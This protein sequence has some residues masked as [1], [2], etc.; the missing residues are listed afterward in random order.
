[1][2]LRRACEACKRNQRKDL[3]PQKKRERGGDSSRERRA[4]SV[5][6]ERACWAPSPF[7]VAGQSVPWAGGP[8]GPAPSAGERGHAC[9]LSLVSATLW[10]VRRFRVLLAGQGVRSRAG[11][12]H[13]PGARPLCGHRHGAT[14]PTAHA[15]LTWPQGGVSQ[16]LAAFRGH[17]PLEGVAA[18]LPHC[19]QAGP[20]AEAPRVRT[21][22]AGRPPLAAGSGLG[23]FIDIVGIKMGAASWDSWLIEPRP[24]FQSTR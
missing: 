10:E 7:H 12:G 3:A 6:A 5:Q 24:C 15:V 13:S 1:M 9:D 8:L 4:W 17:F 20:Q 19:T 14:G 23:G 22:A 21:W 2:P 18:S 11:Q 16:V